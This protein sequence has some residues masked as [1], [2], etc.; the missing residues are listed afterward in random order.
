ML[1][2]MLGTDAYEAHL[3][4]P[5][6]L[7]YQE[8]ASRVV[9]AGVAAAGPVAAVLD[10][11]CD[12]MVLDAVHFLWRPFLPDADDDMVL[13]LA[14]AAGSRYIVTHNVRDFRGSERFGITAL[15]PRDFL[16]LM[17]AET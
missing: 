14:V 9:S 1:L 4:V 7:E 8:Q 13:E 5:L 6:Y 11:V 2:R 15:P 12:S 3:T 17:R 10:Y 16:G